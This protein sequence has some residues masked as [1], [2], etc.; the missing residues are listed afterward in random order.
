MLENQPSNPQNVNHQ[1]LFKLSYSK[2]MSHVCRIRSKIKESCMSYRIRS[3]IESL[4]TSKMAATDKHLV[5]NVAK[6][7][8][9]STALL[10]VLSLLLEVYKKFKFKSLL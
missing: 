3:K 4:V 5:D 2:S 9:L 6:E 1:I 7:Q 10:A 8:Q